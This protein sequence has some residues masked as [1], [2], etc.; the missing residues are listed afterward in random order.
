MSRPV[1]GVG[2]ALCKQAQPWSRRGEARLLVSVASQL[3]G[4][5]TVLHL[6][7]K[8]LLCV[9]M[10]LESLSLPGRALPFSPHCPSL[11]CT[12]FLSKLSFLPGSHFN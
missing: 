11:F 2:C 7:V 6:C 9:A 8:V 10:H 5:S 4:S 12:N 3:S 1:R